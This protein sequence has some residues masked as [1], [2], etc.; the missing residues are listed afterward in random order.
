MIYL[1]NAAGSWPKPES[2]LKALGEAPALYGANPGRGAYQ[3]T[4][5][6]SRMVLGARSE[7][8]E[9]FHCPLAE[10]L[11]F[12]A[13]ATASLN[14][15]ILGLLKEGD[16]VVISSLEHNAVW[17]PLA[18]LQNNG[19]I[20]LT[21]IRPGP[22]GRINP[23][24]F[25]QAVKPQTKLI[26]CVHASNVTGVVNPIEEVGQI[27]AKHHIPL[28]VDAAQSAGVLPVD[29]QKMNIALLAF[30]GHKSLYGPAGVGGL[31]VREDVRIRPLI[32]G[33]TGSLSE[34]W[35]QPEFYPDHLEAGSI[36]TVGIAG[37]QAGLRFVKEQ[38]VTEIY[39]R[40]MGLANAFMEQ[41]S[42]IR[43]VKV[44]TP[45]GDGQRVPVVLLNIE[46]IDT[47]EAAFLLDSDY[48]VCVRGGLHCTPLAH[49]CLGTMESGALRFS[50]G[51][52]NT[53]ADVEGAVKAVSGVAR[54]GY[55]A[56]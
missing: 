8:A 4:L 36:N 23:A 30:A 22:E 46:N 41:V 3:M 1:D 14:T 26:C 5:T 52:F 54:R 12:T 18:Y 47:S 31:Y 45:Q 56:K 50:F 33:G 17:R 27:A 2:V 40:T 29:V 43:G 53:M 34:Q 48:E 28:L 19:T 20:E 49:R 16:H 7:L 42:Q 32:Y 44:Y 38:G 10:R 37:L 11:V 39:G 13:G 15:A 24:D 51:C 9:F 25:E 55:I 6:T 21:V 35:Q